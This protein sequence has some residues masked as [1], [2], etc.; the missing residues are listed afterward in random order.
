MMG[1]SFERIVNPD[2]PCDHCRYLTTSAELGYAGRY[3]ACLHPTFMEYYEEHNQMLMGYLLETGQ[4]PINFDKQYMNKC[5]L[6]EPEE[7][8]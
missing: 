8:A 2:P 7:D 3:N 5:S 6:M 1:S 4:P